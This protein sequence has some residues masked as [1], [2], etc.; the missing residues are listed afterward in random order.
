[1]YFL[2]ERLEGFVTASSV[3]VILYCLF[4]LGTEEFYEWYMT[5][6]GSCWLSAL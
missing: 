2:F 6:Y 3:V 4:R 5:F 1:V